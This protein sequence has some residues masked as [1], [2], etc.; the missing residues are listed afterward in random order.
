M[1]VLASTFRDTQ[2][3]YD[4]VPNAALREHLP[5]M[6]P[7]ELGQAVRLAFPDAERCVRSINGKATRGWCGITGPGGRRTDDGKY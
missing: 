7:A 3:P 2:D 5:D 1:R 6:K 4:W